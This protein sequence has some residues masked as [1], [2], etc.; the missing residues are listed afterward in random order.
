M[1]IYH[2]GDL[3]K[4]T[5]PDG[6]MAHACSC[7]GVWGSGIA[8]QFRDLYPEA[9]ED[10]KYV[11][12]TVGDDLVGS[13]VFLTNC[14]IC[15]TTSKDYGINVDSPFE[16]LRNTEKAIEDLATYGIEEIWIPKINSGL[17]KVPWAS[18][19]KILQKFDNINFNVC[20]KE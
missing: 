11:C 4:L 9:Y 14:I 19:V 18:T 7:K 12:H 15:L 13:A 3:F 17:F 2:Y 8:A 16:I 6:L 10:Y 5:P 1:V 20:I